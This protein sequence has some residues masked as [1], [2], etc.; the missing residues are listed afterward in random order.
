MKRRSWDFC[1]EDNKIGALFLRKVQDFFS[2][3]IISVRHIKTALG[4]DAAIRLDFCRRARRQQSA[5][6]FW[7]DGND[8]GMRGFQKAWTNR[9]GLLFPS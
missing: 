5:H 3:L 7:T 2:P 8:A 4:P 1:L 6:H 9:W